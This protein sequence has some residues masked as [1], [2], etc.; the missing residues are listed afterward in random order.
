MEIRPIISALMRSKVAL[1]RGPLVY[2]FESI[3]NGGSLKELSVRDDVQLIAH[4]RPEM[5]GGIVVLEADG[6]FAIPYFANANRSPV[7]M[8][9]WI[10][11]R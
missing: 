10:A 9:T 1:M 4:H 2:C 6:R 7:E 3:D 8:K 5:L 11:R